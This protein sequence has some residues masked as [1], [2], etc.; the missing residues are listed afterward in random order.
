MME[1]LTEMNELPT[2]L[3]LIIFVHWIAQAFHNAG[4]NTRLTRLE[5]KR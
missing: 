1:W 3:I 4:T 2:W 5:N